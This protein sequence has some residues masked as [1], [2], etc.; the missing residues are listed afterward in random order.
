MWSSN[1]VTKLHS[2]TGRE[3]HS[4]SGPGLCSPCSCSVLR[5]NSRLGKAKIISI[6]WPAS[7]PFAGAGRPSNAGKRPTSSSSLLAKA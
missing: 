4:P 1:S 7:G 5:C 3:S 6:V 2:T